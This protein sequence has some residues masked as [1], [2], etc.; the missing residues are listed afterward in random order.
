[1]KRRYAGILAHI[2]SLPSSYGIGDLGKECTTRFLTFMK[3]I[4]H[5]LWSM[6]PLNPADDSNSPYS[7]RSAFAG[8]HLLIATNE[9]VDSPIEPGLE[10]PKD[11][12]RV[13]YKAVDQYKK[14]MLWNAF[15]KNRGTLG[16][17]YE[18]FKKSTDWL[19]DYAVFMA[20]AEVNNGNYNWGTWPQEGLKKHDE[21]AI[22][23]F[24][25]KNED[26]VEFQTYIQY[27]FF[28]QLESLK[29]RANE[30][31]ILLL[32]DLACYVNYQ[33]ADVWAH[34]EL[35]EI[36]PNTL[37]ITGASGVTPDTPEKHST[38]QWWGHPVYRWA[39]N[40]KGVID[41]WV[42]RL[43]HMAKYFDRVRIDHAL[44]LMSYCTMPYKDNP[45]HEECLDMAAAGVWRDAPGI[46]LFQDKRLKEILHQIFL[47]DRGPPNEIDKVLAMK[48][49]FN[50]PGMIILPDAFGIYAGKEAKPHNIPPDCYY[51]LGSHD[52]PPIRDRLE[53]APLDMIYHLLE[54][55]NVTDPEKAFDAL[56]HLLY[57]SVSRMVV[58]Q[59]QDI[60]PYKKGS[61]MNIP[62]QQFDQ[63]EWKF[64]MKEFQGIPVETIRL[65]KKLVDIYERKQ[66]L[67]DLDFLNVI[68]SCIDLRNYQT[69]PLTRI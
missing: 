33:S 15:K 53:S 36:D 14:K 59:M 2:T 7:S 18:K 31:G 10:H 52:D 34:K 56:L 42:S 58:L 60:L 4:D 44:G 50:F 3:M 11:P 26:L 28:Q 16:E 25:K 13:N 64:T 24:V 38:G 57:G 32:G 8:N 29:K 68:I 35:F 23:E 48:E 30:M 9:I 12:N 49:K 66:Q 43:L 6:L 45:T 54:Y 41:W 5:S 40:P 1:M 67:I 22:E 65:F 20:A 27:V 21:K 51:Y 46:E 19:K 62:G 63:W 69:Y 17:D 55:A 61:R 47:E 37:K 39:D